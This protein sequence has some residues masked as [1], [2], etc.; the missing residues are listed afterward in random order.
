MSRGAQENARVRKQM[1]EALFT[2]LEK[3]EFS[4]I[5]VTDIITEAKVARTSFYRNFDTK[6]A[7][8]EAYMELVYRELADS[9]NEPDFDTFYSYESLVKRFEHSFSFLL[10]KKSYILALYKNGFASLILEVMNRY[11]ED[12][13]GTMPHRSTERYKLYFV[14][15][16]AFNVLITWLEEGAVESPREMAEACAGFLFGDII[17][18]AKE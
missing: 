8:V 6:E 1:T 3:K 15:G 11:I 9:D 5:T 4:E 10:Q 12:A 16:A 7:I 2:L 18:T 14:T 17:K 13:A